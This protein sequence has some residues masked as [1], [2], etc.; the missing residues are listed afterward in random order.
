MRQTKTQM[1]DVLLEEGRKISEECGV[2]NLP[3]EIL[4]IIGRYKFR[5]SYGQN[6]ALHTIEETKIGVAIANE[7]G[8]KIDIVRLGCLLHDIGKV[9]ADEEGTHVDAG[10]SIL[11][12]GSRR[13]QNM[14]A[15]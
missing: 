9:V 2:Y 1:D 14:R 8:A 7:I 3:T 6:L 10:V 15:R 13:K 5:T 12:K 11:K 4:K